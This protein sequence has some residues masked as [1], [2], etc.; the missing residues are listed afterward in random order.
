MKKIM[1]AALVAGIAVPSRSQ[2]VSM[3]AVGVIPAAQV[4]DAVISGQVPLDSPASITVQP[5]AQQP[6]QPAHV[7]PASSWT[8]NVDFKDP[9]AYGPWVARNVNEGLWMGGPIVAP[10]SVYH[11]NDASGSARRWFRAGG[12]VL[13][14]AEGGNPY[15]AAAGGIDVLQWTSQAVVAGAAAK[16]A[17]YYKPFGLTSITADV[18]GW[19]GVCPRHDSQ[20]AHGDLGYGFGFQLTGKFGESA[21][22]VA[23]DILKAGL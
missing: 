20:I 17:N 11:V 13:M 3:P 5:V 1:L 19:V 2:N 22:K 6:A 9:D 23:Q 7:Y 16:A 4:Q 15:Y 21:A 8:Y 10:L 18:N 12:G 14:N